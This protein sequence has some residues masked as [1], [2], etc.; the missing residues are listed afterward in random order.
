MAD[1][2]LCLALNRLRQTAVCWGG[3]GWKRM[4][5]SFAAPTVCQVEGETHCVSGG[6]GGDLLC[7]RWGGRKRMGN[8]YAAPTVC[9]WWGGGVETHCVS[10]EQWDLPE[11]HVSP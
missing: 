9:R 3:G 4:G 6:G 7:V 8:S 10:G 11:F 2:L 5:N 1:E